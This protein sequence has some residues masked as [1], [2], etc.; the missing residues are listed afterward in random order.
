ML[1]QSQK[2]S[3]PFSSINLQS[4]YHTTNH[5]SPPPLNSNPLHNQEEHHIQH[6][7]QAGKE[8]FSQVG[9]T[10]FSRTFQESEAATE[11]QA[12]G[13]SRTTETK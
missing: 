11:L 3:P 12:L 8:L 4:L 6:S 9:L 5:H 1:Q 7:H 13:T 2:S 10:N